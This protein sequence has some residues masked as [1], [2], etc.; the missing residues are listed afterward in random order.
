MTSYFERVVN[1]STYNQIARGSEP[2]EKLNN[3]SSSAWDDR[4]LIACHVI[5]GSRNNKLLPRLKQIPRDDLEDD[6]RKQIDK[7]VNG[8]DEKRQDQLENELVHDP[9]V[10][11]SL[12][13]IWDALYNLYA[14]ESGLPQTSTDSLEKRSCQDNS[15]EDTDGPRYP[16]RSRTAVSK[17]GY[18]DPGNVFT[19]SPPR[20][21]QFDPPSSQTE[22][23]VESMSPKGV[24]LEDYT[25]RLVFCI[26]RH[27]L[28]H[29][30]K[31]D[32]SYVEVRERQRAV[33]SINGREVIAIDDGGL[34]LTSP[35][36]NKTRKS[37]V[38]IEA[39]R[40]LE[41]SQDR[42]VVSD[43]VLGQMLCEAIAARISGQEEC[44]DVFIINSTS[45]YMCFFN[46]EISETQLQEITRGKKPVK[47]IKVNATRWLNVKDARQ[48]QHIARNIE[49]LSGYL[50]RVSMV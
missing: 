30:Q 20:S 42:V 11:T 16:K 3:V 44:D 37:I 14:T 19:S 28:Y 27:I 26:L 40:R 9:E 12:A 1:E 32:S 7:F 35:G 22:G 4:H 17:P 18:V 50:K 2:L 47:P 6:M 5:V 34:C 38:L 48:R 8:L 25:V 39:K 36:R 24:V 46:F 10:G 29:C 23:Y 33:V 43:S 31:P 45:Y 15:G 49:R 21:S 13:Q 41:V